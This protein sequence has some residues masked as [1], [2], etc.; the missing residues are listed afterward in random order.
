MIRINELEAD[1]RIETVKRRMKEKLVSFKSKI[2]KYQKKKKKK[3]IES[4]VEVKAEIIIETEQ[5]KIEILRE[6]IE[7]KSRELN[8][9]R[10]LKKKEMKKLI[11]EGIN[12]EV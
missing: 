4:G 7:R 2:K 8:T 5:S 12:Q 10:K 9:K 3:K 1:L 6:V 11:I